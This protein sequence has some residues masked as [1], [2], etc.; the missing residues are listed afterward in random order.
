MTNLPWSFRHPIFEAGVAVLQSSDARTWIWPT[1]VKS[2]CWTTA[3]VEA[4]RVEST[5]RTVVVDI[6]LDTWVVDR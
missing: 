2:R 1:P 6:V 3:W 5:K 4:S